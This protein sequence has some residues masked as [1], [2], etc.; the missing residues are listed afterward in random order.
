MKAK[1]LK[2]WE[3]VETIA[4]GMDVGGARPETGLVPIATPPQEPTSKKLSLIEA[5]FS[6][7]S[8]MIGPIGLPVFVGFS[9]GLDRMQCVRSL[10]Q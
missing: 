8:G 6:V 3:C 1:V 9:Y 5:M 4:L 2:V 7:Y 10:Q